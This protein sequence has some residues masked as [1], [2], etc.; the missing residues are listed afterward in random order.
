MVLLQVLTDESIGQVWDSVEREG[1]QAKIFETLE[2]LCA[3]PLI[4]VALYA[5]WHPPKNSTHGT[6]L[7]FLELAN[8][9]IN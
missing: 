7:V 3:T 6:G 9:F 8:C 5:F 4:N 1:P 2:T